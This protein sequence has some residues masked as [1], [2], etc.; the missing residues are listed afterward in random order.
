MEAISVP[1]PPRFV[2]TMSE[3]HS[4]VKPESKSAA[5]T[6]LMTWLLKTATSVTRPSKMLERKSRNAGKRPIFPMKTKKKI[7]VN[8]KL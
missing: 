2:P 7:K 8:N 5:G 6:L 3:V 1:R 4:F